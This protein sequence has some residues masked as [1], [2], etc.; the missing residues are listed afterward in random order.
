MFKARNLYRKIM[1]SLIGCVAVGGLVA[2]TS[3]PASAAQEAPIVRFGVP[4]WPGITVQ[5]QVAAD[6]LEAM[7]Y[8]T[9]QVSTSPAFALSALRT[10]DLDVYLGGWMPVEKDMIEPMAK[11][12]QVTVLTTNISNALMGLAVPKYV[13]DAGVHTVDDL[14]KHADKF[15]KKIY[16]IEPGSGFNEL[17]QKAIK[18]NQHSLGDWRMIPS[19]TSAMLAQVGRA[20]K[21]KN[22]IVFLGWEPHSMNIIW[23]IKYLQAVGKPTIAHTKSD[24]L[25]VVNT[26]L[27][28]AKPQAA[29]FLKQF[30][31]PKKAMSEW[32]LQYK[33]KKRKATDIA[34]EWIGKH[35]DLVATWMD[36]VKALNG[37]PAMDAIKAK[38]AS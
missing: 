19:S 11:K 31:V 10:D 30:Q 38:Y 28:Q 25:T 8:R 9:K 6:L 33:N 18:T 17:I 13:W 3:M 36:G 29:L 20:I 35:Q 22:W 34:T 27:A 24:V 23:D 12:K 26:R 16:G 32:I 5:S 7:G 15:N 4:T 14:N 21:R 37:Q 1:F 2:G